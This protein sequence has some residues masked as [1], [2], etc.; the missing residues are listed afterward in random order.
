L[1]RQV[2]GAVAF[3]LKNWLIV[4][5]GLLTLIFYQ[6]N[7]IF[8]LLGFKGYLVPVQRSHCASKPSQPF[9]ERS[10]S[11]AYDAQKCRAQ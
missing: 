9:G 11:R 6:R 8:L 2:V 5:F 1:K 7:V 10:A 4:K 3:S